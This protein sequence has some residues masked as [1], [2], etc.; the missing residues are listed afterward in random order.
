ML[1]LLLQLLLEGLEVNLEVNLVFS[2]WRPESDTRDGIGGNLPCLLHLYVLTLPWLNR[3]CES[4][5]L[6]TICHLTRPLDSILNFLKGMNAKV[7]ISDRIIWSR[8]CWAFVCSFCS[9]WKLLVT[10]EHLLLSLTG[11]D[12]TFKSLSYYCSF[13]DWVCLFWRG[14]LINWRNFQIAGNVQFTA[15][16]HKNI[17]YRLGI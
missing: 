2:S 3:K 8:V 16:S 9:K 1:I 5:G 17:T 4:F 12:R 11:Y 7:S 14:I 15:L 6:M 10:F 13:W